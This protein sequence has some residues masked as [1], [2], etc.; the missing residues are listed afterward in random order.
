MRALRGSD[1]AETEYPSWDGKPMAE[2]DLHWHWMVTIVQRLKLHFAGRRVYVA[3]NLLIYYEEGDPR[4]SV[5]PDAFVV[6]NC[7]PG[8]RD[9]FRIWHERRILPL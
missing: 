7:K 5:A 6:K 4:K 9:T 3:G 8:R 1:L 2:T